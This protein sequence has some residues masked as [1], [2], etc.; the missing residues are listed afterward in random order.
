M[1]QEPV[2]FV[3]CSRASESILVRYGQPSEVQYTKLGSGG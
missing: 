1:S 3:P 2:S